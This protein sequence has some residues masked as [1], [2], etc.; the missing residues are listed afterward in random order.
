[1]IGP[2][3]YSIYSSGMTVEYLIQISSGVLEHYHKINY[4]LVCDI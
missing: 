1:M 2:S 4:S 3:Y